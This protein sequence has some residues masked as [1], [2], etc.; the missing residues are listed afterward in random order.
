MKTII[1]PSMLSGTLKIP[2]SK[3]YM[4]RA[5]AA[6][7]I[8]RG[9]SIIH[10]AGHSKDDEA[11][12]NVIQQLGAKVSRQNNLIFITSNSISAISDTIN[13]NESG[14]SS[15]MFTSIAALENK[16]LKITGEGSLLKRPFNFF[17]KILPQLG[18]TIHTNNGYL[19]LTIQGPLSPHN[20]IIDGS[21]SSQFLTGLL[22]SFSAAN[23]TDV[24]IEVNNL[25]S[26]PYIDITLEVLE[27]FELKTPINNNYESFYFNSESVSN[28]KNKIE[29]TIEADWSSAS[30]IVV[31]A[32]IAGNVVL[33]GLN[34]NSLQADKRLLEVLEI[35]KINFQFINDDVNINTSI[36][37]PFQFDAT[38]CPDLFPALVVLAAYA[39]GIST[40]KGVNRLEHKE[41]NR[42]DTLK[43]EFSKLGVQIIIDNDE[44]IIYGTGIVNGGIVNSH[45][46][47]RITMACA[48]AALKAE[49]KIIIQESESINKSYPDFFK[50]LISLGANVSLTN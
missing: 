35:A 39:K 17:E 38:E 22:M 20:I 41:S 2:S 43:K 21:L 18:V 36:I 49:S 50:H 32:A 29:Y 26:K 4:Q 33:K 8:R 23:A 15:R 11:S 5:C 30:F 13:C 25:V 47:H 3:S 45:S 27:K 40:I 16:K 48:I 7:L 28:N 12:I 24:I 31:G 46:D 44:M 42:S 1:H 19:P 34:K 37:H 10:N 6:A 9:E 14:L